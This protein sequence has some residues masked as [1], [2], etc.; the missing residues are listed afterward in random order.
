[1]R[2]PTKK[3][4]CSYAGLV[5]GASNVWEY[6]PRHNLLKRW[7]MILKYALIWAMIRAISANKL[8]VIKMHYMVV[9]QRTSIAHKAEVAAVRRSRA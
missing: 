8:K 3:Q 5:L 9:E 6:E 1:L 4:L 2:F 7:N